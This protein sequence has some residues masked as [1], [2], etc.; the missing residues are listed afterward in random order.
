MRGVN[1]GFRRNKADHFLDQTYLWNMV[2]FILSE[3]TD[4]EKLT[5]Q[6]EKSWGKDVYLD[7]LLN[8]L[9]TEDSEGIF[10]FQNQKIFE[11]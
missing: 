3:G 10:I 6:C 1:D 4:K 8:G 7:Q 5:N 2:S 9:K 11:G